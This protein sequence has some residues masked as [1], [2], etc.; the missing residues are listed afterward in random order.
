MTQIGRTDTQSEGIRE[1]TNEEIAVVAGGTPSTQC[2]SIQSLEQRLCGI[3]QRV[4][5]CF[6]L[7]QTPG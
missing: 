5:S 1:L 7:Q 4:L 6:G 2:F 3:I